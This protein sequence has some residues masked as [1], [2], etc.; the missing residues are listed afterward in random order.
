M[1]LYS[2]I[3]KCLTTINILNVLVVQ[4]AFFQF[5]FENF[6]FFFGIKISIICL[7]NQRTPKQALSAMHIN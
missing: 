1:K 2:L 7:Y 6:L 3:I 5:H 4:A